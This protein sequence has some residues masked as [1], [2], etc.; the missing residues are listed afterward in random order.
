MN[1]D[2]L[3][4]MAL[5]MHD[6]LQPELAK[7]YLDSARSMDRQQ[8][9]R[10]LDDS[11][12]KPLAE[13][14]AEDLKLFDIVVPSICNRCWMPYYKTDIKVDGPM[15]VK[16]YCPAC[17]DYGAMLEFPADWVYLVQEWVAEAEADDAG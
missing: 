13:E 7:A 11:L 10:S 6:A 16:P 9:K 12:V 5:M 14:I 2:D 17:E 8:K 3:L 1:P 4:D 15:K